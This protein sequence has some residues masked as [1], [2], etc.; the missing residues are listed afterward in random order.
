MESLVKAPRCQQT[1]DKN[2]P[3]CTLPAGEKRTITKIG[4]SV[5]V[6]GNGYDLR[7]IKMNTTPSATIVFVFRERLSSTLPCLQHLLSTTLSPYKLICVDGG[8][9]ESISAS[10]RQLASSH[11]FTLLRSEHYLSPNESRNL[12]LKHVHT[13]Y[14]VFIDNDVKV[15]PDWLDPL[16]QCAEETGAWL[17]APL[18]ME[19]FKGQQRVHMF[20]GTVR[21]RDEGGQ[22]A[23][24]EKHNLEHTILNGEAHLVRQETDLIEFHTLL[25]N[26]DAYRILG[27]LD[28]KLFS[29]SE[30][31]DLSL[32]V[33]AA[34]KQIYLEPSSVITYEIPDHLD[35]IDR[36]YFALRWSEAWTEASLERLAE[37]YAIPL[38]DRGLRKAGRWVTR[39]RQGAMRPYPRIR[40][41]LG[42]NGHRIFRRLI[43][44]P[45]D[46][47]RNIRQYA[48]PDYVINR[49]AEARVI[50]QQ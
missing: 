25:M 19:S 23:Y 40:R 39:H 35:M 37:K 45:L 20:G 9:P 36:E 33:K 34:G 43:A 38:K 29:C 28:E 8:A 47:W 5:F 48:P 7:P 13:P 3:D 24:F 17:V 46:S 50:S 11:G 26:M 1:S 16:V 41:W 27:P 4:L 10:L 22:P 15:S 6:R 18:Y 12:A 2:Q 42:T 14:V 44:Q 31:A 32:I 49:K 30:H 21:V